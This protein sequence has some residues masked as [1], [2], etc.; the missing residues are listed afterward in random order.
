VPE[1]S[2]VSLF[3]S[4]CFS[5]SRGKFVTPWEGKP[6]FS[7]HSLNFSHNLEA[8]TMRGLHYQEEPFAQG[9]LVHCVAGR[10]FDVVV[11]LRKN[12]S[13]YLQWQSFELDAQTSCTLQIPAGFAHGFLTLEPATIICYLIEGDYNSAMSRGIRWNDPALGIKWPMR[14]PKVI[15]E[16]DRSLPDLCL[17]PES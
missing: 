8:G 17:C 3:P 1:E 12:S 6:A 14:E 16:K 4:P 7:P 2:S 10:A 9:K 15:S 5:D 13:S 11:D